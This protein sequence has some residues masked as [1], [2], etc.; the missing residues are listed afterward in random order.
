MATQGID[1][2]T[3]SSNGIR[4]NHGKLFT[5]EFTGKRLYELLNILEERACRSDHY[6]EVRKCVDMAQYIRALARAQ[7]F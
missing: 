3:C 7:G 1:L 2:E 6:H 4:A 5:L